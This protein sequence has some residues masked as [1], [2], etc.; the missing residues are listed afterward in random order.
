MII[1][2]STIY[3]VSLSQPNSGLALLTQ[4][5]ALFQ[6]LDTLL[7]YLETTF[8]SLEVSMKLQKN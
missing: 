8:S 4:T 7:K 2:N 5:K 3:G 6:D 1:T